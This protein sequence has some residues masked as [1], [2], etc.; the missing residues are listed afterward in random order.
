MK[1]EKEAMSSLLLPRF[2]V[3][4]K[5]IHTRKYGKGLLSHPSA[6]YPVLETGHLDI[7]RCKLRNINYPSLNKC[8][9]VSA[10]AMTV[11]FFFFFFNPV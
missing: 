10:L 2:I 3:N 1:V 8:C 4:E 6:S 9:R 7:S 5:C 11:K